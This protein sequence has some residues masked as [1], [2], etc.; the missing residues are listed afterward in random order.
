MLILRINELL[1][2]AGVAGF[3]INGVPVKFL[4]GADGDVSEQ[5]GLGHR[6]GDAEIRTC[7]LAGFAR[8]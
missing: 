5:D 8:P 1:G 6:A 7:R 4:A 2:V 3:E